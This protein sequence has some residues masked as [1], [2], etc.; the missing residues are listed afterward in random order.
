[1][2]LTC[3]LRPSL[4]IQNSKVALQRPLSMDYLTELTTQGEQICERTPKN[5]ET[6]YN[7]KGFVSTS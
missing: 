4:N 2:T 7:L 5:F 6:S 3:P 1:M